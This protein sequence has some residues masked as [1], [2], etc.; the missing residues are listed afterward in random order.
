MNKLFQVIV[1][2][3]PHYTW[4]FA[5]AL[6]TYIIAAQVTENYT[7]PQRISIGLVVSVLFALITA[8]RD[9]V[10]GLLV[11]RSDGGKTF[12]FAFGGVRRENKENFIS[13]HLML[14]YLIKFLSTLIIAVIFWGLYATFI[15]F[16]RQTMAEVA[17]WLAF[18][19]FLV[20]LLH[21]VPAFP[22]DGGKILR[23]LLWKIKKDY[24]ESTRIASI[25]GLGTG[26]FLIFV[27]VLVFIISRQWYYSLTILFLG[28]SV[29][30]AAAY[31]LNNANTG[32]ALRDIKAA[33]IM[34]GDFP[35]LSSQLSIAQL[36][37]EYILVKGWRYVL[38][39]DS[40]KFRGM[41]T[42]HQAYAV[43]EKSRISTKIEDIMLSPD[44]AGFAL[45]SDPGDVVL[46]QLYSRNSNFI[47]VIDNGKVIGVV[48]RDS[49]KNLVRI[50]NAFGF[51]AQLR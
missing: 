36:L 37:Q 43:P 24:Y 23:V 18:I 29:S 26:L 48:S 20:F 46:E 13:T 40:G 25:I 27:A 15:N 47:P 41:L 11:E 34:T 2:Y 39:I 14:L 16:D 51:R 49:L 35:V 7:L 22:L 8:L 4:I 32:I 21:I 38:V 9:L 45:S 19:Y 50:R 17:Q 44:K 5:V 33:D 3:R 12:L 30:V 42:I 6:I 31:T 1:S 10:L 28:W